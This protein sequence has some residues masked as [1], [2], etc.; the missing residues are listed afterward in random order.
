M[1]EIVN[2]GQSGRYISKCAHSPLYVYC[3]LVFSFG[4]VHVHLISC[5]VNLPFLVCLC[6]DCSS[7]F[8]HKDHEG[9]VKITGRVGLFVSILQQL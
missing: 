6:L 5:V 7:Q 3:N 9:T 8:Y 2:T 1:C 4:N